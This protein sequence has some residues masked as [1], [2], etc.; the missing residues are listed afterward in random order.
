[1]FFFTQR[2]MK[3][4]ISQSECFIDDLSAIYSSKT[5]IKSSFIDHACL[6]SYFFGTLR[7][8]ADIIPLRPSR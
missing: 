6:L 3:E 8:R 7:P 1:M 5:I 2:Q 4:Q